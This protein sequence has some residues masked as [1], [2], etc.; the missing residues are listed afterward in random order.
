VRAGSVGL[1][2]HTHP[3]RSEPLVKV[4]QQVAA[5]QAL[6]LLKIGLV[7]LPVSA[8]RAGVV[9]RIVAPDASAV[10]FGEPLIELA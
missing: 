7:L 10:G 9:S 8:P 2:L 3:L 4:G 6:A 5:G 1:L